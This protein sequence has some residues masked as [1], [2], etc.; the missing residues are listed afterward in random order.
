MR[1]VL[2]P[3]LMDMLQNRIYQ[4]LVIET[5]LNEWWLVPLGD[6]GSLPYQVAVTDNGKYIMDSVGRIV[7][8]FSIPAR[9]INTLWVRSWKDFE[10]LDQLGTEMR[11]KRNDGSAELPI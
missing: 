5:F 1:Y 4:N 2:D 10:I 11:E 9:R 8:E 7:A 6:R 3:L